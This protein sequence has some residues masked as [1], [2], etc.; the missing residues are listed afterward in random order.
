MARVMILS[1]RFPHTHPKKGLPT[2]FIEAF[3]QGLL[4]NELVTPSELKQYQDNISKEEL[5]QDIDYRFLTSQ[6]YSKVHTIRA[7]KNLKVG[8]VRSPRTWI[9]K[10][11]KQPGQIVLG[12]DITIRQ[13]YDFTF[14]KLG[15]VYTFDIKG[16][17]NQMK[18]SIAIDLSELQV[19]HGFNYPKQTAKQI[20]QTGHPVVDMMTRNDNLNLVDFIRWFFPHKKRFKKNVPRQKAVFDG[21]I[22]SW[23]DIDWYGLNTPY[24][25]LPESNVF[26]KTVKMSR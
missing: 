17:H 25:E 6:Y 16:T 12:P 24:E 20:Y 10:P 1:C 26:V 8:D 9:E 13:I 23:I 19:E 2:R 5:M 3:H 4:I 15:D 11:R 7:G 14:S 18:F 22:A 21:Q